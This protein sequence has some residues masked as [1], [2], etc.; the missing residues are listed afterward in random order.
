[1]MFLPY[2]EIKPKNSRRTPDAY[3]ME[4]YLGDIARYLKCCEN[5]HFA[6]L[7]AM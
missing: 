4:E 5:G 1:M 2:G 3:Q 6:M 7:A